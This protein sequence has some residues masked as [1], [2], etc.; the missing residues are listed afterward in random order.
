MVVAASS[1]TVPPQGGRLCGICMDDVCFEDDDD[2]GAR[3]PPC[4][5]GPPDAVFHARCLARWRAQSARCPHCNQHEDESASMPTELHRML[6]RWMLDAR[7]GRRGP[8]F[9]RAARGMLRGGAERQAEREAVHAVLAALRANRPSP[10]VCVTRVDDAT[11]RFTAVSR[12]AL[13]LGELADGK[14]AVVTLKRTAEWSRGRVC[15][16]GFELCLNNQLRRRRC[17]R[18]L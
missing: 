10:D 2:N 7:V 15:S 16:D 1:S 17:G 14:K 11:M 6:C 18:R 13:R 12:R 9:V 5:R 8:I 3:P 4:G